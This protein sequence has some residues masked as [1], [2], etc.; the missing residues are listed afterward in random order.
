M[1]IYIFINIIK[2]LKKKNYVYKVVIRDPIY[3][4]CDLFKL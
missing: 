3:T 2:N 1:V 4:A